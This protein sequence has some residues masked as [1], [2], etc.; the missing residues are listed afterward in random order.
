MGKMDKIQICVR[1]RQ[2]M[3]VMTFHRVA[4]EELKHMRLSQ[5]IPK[6]YHLFRL[7]CSQ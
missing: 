4:G 6:S 5:A 7:E 2:L 1:I 3:S